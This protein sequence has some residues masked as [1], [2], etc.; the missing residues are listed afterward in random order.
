MSLLGF[1]MA[2]GSC[3]E[4]NGVRLSIGKGNQAFAEEMA[5]NFLHVFGCLRWFTPALAVVPS[6][7]S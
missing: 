3:S 7:S 1:Y 2:E 4:R 5:N 6:S